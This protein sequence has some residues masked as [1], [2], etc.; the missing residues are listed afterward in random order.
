MDDIEGILVSQEEQKL[1]IVDHV[2]D[3]KHVLEEDQCG[4]EKAADRDDDE[5][6]DESEQIQ[7]IDRVEED[8]E[9]NEIVVLE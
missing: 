2:L 3:N 5:K 7:E 6:S 4:L 1:L 9:M 8:K